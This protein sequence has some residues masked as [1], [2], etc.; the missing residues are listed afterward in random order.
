[1]DAQENN[2]YNCH[3]FKKLTIIAGIILIHRQKHPCLSLNNL[4]LFIFL[5]QIISIGEKMINIF[6]SYSTFCIV[7]CLRPYHVENTS[8][9]PITEVKQHRAELV[10]GWVTA[11]EYS[12]LQAFSFNT[13][14]NPNIKNISFGLF[15]SE[16]GCI[17]K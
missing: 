3:Y 14:F 5:N 16:N 6:V 15:R 10:L 9:R 11:W 13:C 8:S 7:S 2:Q 17:E 1:M 12:V 4:C